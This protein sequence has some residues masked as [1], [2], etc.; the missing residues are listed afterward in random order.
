MRRRLSL[1]ATSVSPLSSDTARIPMS[2]RWRRDPP[3][4]MT[5][6][7]RTPR[8]AALAPAMAGVLKARASPI[9]TQR[10]KPGRVT[11]TRPVRA[12]AS[13]SE[14]E[15]DADPD[16]LIVVEE[17]PHG[18]SSPVDLEWRIPELEADAGAV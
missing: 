16:L 3:M 17:L 9:A 8:G 2:A 7:A 13:C 6:S 12:S 4:A 18:R 15:R 14:L 11:E 5:E 10:R 1:Y